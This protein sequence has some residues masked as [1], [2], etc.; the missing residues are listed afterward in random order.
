MRFNPLLLL[1]A[2][3]LA[4]ASAFVVPTGSPRLAARTATTMAA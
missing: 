1:V 3:A 4:S 2:T